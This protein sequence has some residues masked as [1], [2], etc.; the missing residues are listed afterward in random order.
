MEHWNKI[1]L[2]L[3]SFY[4]ERRPVTAGWASWIVCLLL[5]LNSFAVTSFPCSVLHSLDVDMKKVC[6]SEH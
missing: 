1:V 4:L 2:L 6:I 3:F 5:F